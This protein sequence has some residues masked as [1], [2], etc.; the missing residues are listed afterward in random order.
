MR[1][2]LDEC[3]PRRLRQAFPD[4]EVITVPDAG[5]AGRSNGELLALVQTRFDVFITVDR[6]LAVQQPVPAMAIGVI[7]LRAKSNRYADL[8]SLVPGITRALGSIL[9]G[10][11]VTIEG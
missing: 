2:L 5:W 9:T 10:Q 8:Q 3:L 4:H 6:N 7:I 1:V 11:V